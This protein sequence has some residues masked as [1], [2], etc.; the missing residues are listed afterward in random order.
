MA[1]ESSRPLLLPQNRRLRHLQGIYLRNLTLTRP[2]G[3]TI[4][5]AALNKS[6]SKLEALREPQLHHAQSS[7]ALNAKT[8]PGK[9]RRR[10]TIWAGQSPGYRQK[11]L[12]DVIGGGM[13][14]SFFSLHVEQIYEPVYV[15]EVIE[16][17]MVCNS[18]KKPWRSSPFSRAYVRLLEYNELTNKR[19]IQR[20]DSSTWPSTAHQ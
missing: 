4:D 6:P 18:L 2:R 14:D 5:D 7:D 16:K 10:S 15:S 17:A 11:K 1:S 13:T 19:R 8:R 9:Q 12:E 20:F 3:H